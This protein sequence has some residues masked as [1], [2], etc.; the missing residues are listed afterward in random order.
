VMTSSGLI[1]I[2]VK[3]NNIRPVHTKFGALSFYRL[4]CVFGYAKARFKGLAKKTSQIVMLLA[5]G[6][7]HRARHKLLEMKEQQEQK[8]LKAVVCL[9][10]GI[11]GED[12]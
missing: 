12:L 10:T 3:L 6:N 2:Y 9:R 5:L 11:K 1:Y 7:L 4:K 8:K